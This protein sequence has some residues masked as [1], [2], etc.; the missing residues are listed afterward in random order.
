MASLIKRGKTY[1]AQY[2]IAGK[3]RRI[4]LETQSLQVAKEKL[5]QLESAMARQDD[6]PIPTKTP[7]PGLLSDYIGHCKTFKTQASI[8]A[9]LFYLRE[10]F[11][12]LCPELEAPRARKHRRPH[13]IE[14]PY[15]EA[16][17]T[18]MVSLF[19]SAQVQDR[20]LSPKSANRYREVLHAFFNWA[21]NERG[22]KMPGGVNPVAK[23][24]RHREKARIIRFLSLQQI[25][26]QLAALQDNPLLQAMVAMY[27]YAGLRRTELVWLTHKDVDLRPTQNVIHVRA[28]TVDGKFWEPKTKQNRVIPISSTLRSWLDHYETRIVPNHWFFPSPHGKQWHPDNVTRAIELANKKAH[29]PWSCADYRHT[30]GSQLAMKGESLYKISEL[31]GNSPD[32]C[33]KHYATLVPHEMRSSVEF[34]TVKAPQ[35]LQTMSTHQAESTFS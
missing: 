13:R 5:R 15:I 29:L 24:K 26:E 16:V 31:M 1:Y 21:M 27:I 35:S 18:G 14:A 30:F 7:L 8:T 33:R 25:D 10:S 2:C 34:G 20:G 12:P 23:T 32:I 6:I 4:S 9:D 11:G 22:V 19:I 17:T 3:A 28:K